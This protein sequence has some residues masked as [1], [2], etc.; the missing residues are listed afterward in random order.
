MQNRQN[1][2]KQW[3]QNTLKISE[4]NLTPLTG[5]AS[6]R[7]YYRLQHAGRSYIVMD[8]PPE[9][10]AMRP[11]LQIQHLL[12]DNQVLTPTVHFVDES[13]G[14]A[15]LDDFG[16]T[17]LL[18]ELTATKSNPQKIDD[19]YIAAIKALIPLQQCHRNADFDLPVFDKTHMLNEL[20]LL[21]TWYLEG[22]L[23]VVLTSAETKL[24]ET[25][26]HTLANEISKQPYVFIHRDY[27]SRNIMLLDQRHTLGIIDFQ[28]AMLGPITYDLVSLLKDCYIQWPAEQVIHW[29][30]IFYDLSE[31]AQKL[32]FPEFK[33]AFDLCGLQRHLK[34][35]GVFSRLFLRDGKA[36]YLADLPITRHY[37][38]AC[39]ESYPE[40][41]SFYELMETRGQLP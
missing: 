27:H 9:K 18:A 14:F 34:V 33:R 16:D 3:L 12:D 35:L 19:L 6:F 11:Y 36:N 15:L 2:L 29:L 28:D 21:K 24:I 1:A 4:I 37:V 13:Q 17:L 38:M 10:E 22:Y 5:D 25:T 7:R 8:A 30:K 20:G 26:C 31:T 41:Y 39:L 32:S 23:K 40:F